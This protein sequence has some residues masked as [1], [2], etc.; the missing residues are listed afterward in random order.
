MATESARTHGMVSAAAQQGALQTGVSPSLALTIFAAKATAKYKDL[1]PDADVEDIVREI[2]QE[3]S[4]DFTSASSSWTPARTFP[5][6][7]HKGHGKA[8]DSVVKG[9]WLKGGKDKAGKVKG[10]E[11]SQAGGQA[12]GKA[13]E[14]DTSARPRARPRNPTP[15]ARPRARRRSP[16][17]RS[18]ARARPRSPT[19]RARPK[20]SPRTLA[21]GS[22]PRPRRRD[23]DW[24]GLVGLA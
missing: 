24:S 18:R 8:K 13:K 16:T 22:S 17:P 9:Q 10:K 23:E 7:S 19:P 21:P 2:M 11:D 20:A 15:R 4:Q 6:A 14:S 3:R 5:K 12:K 1:E